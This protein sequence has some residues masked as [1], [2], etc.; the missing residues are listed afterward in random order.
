M[1][2][3]LTSHSNRSEEGERREKPIRKRKRAETKAERAREIEELMGV[4]PV[5]DQ[6]PTTISD[7]GENN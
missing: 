6:T 3:D 5:R 1:S 2:Q 4:S 7:E